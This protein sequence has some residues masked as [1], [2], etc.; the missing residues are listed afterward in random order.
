MKKRLERIKNNISSLSNSQIEL[1]E[2]IIKQ[3][4]LPY[5]EIYRHKDS[6]IFTDQVLLDF[7]DVLKI[8]HCFSYEPFTK[9]K[10]EFAL[11]R[12]LHNCNF[13]ANLAPKGNPGHDIEIN[14]IRFSLKTQA[15]KSTKS[16]KIHISKFMELGKGEWSDNPNDLNNLLNLF[17]NHLNGYDRILSLRCLQKVPFWKYEVVEIPKS[18]LFEAKY[19]ELR[20]MSKSYQNPK[21]GYCD[22]TDENGNIKF[23]LYFDGGSERKLQVK[24]LGKIYCI[25]QATWCF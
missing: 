13:N 6:D 25:V 12:T 18:L 7:G 24:N 17:F 22:V 4:N 10:F 16:D 21:P 8:H 23:Q 1:I 19:G 14:G 3:F 11:E 20:M 9:D 5:K 2:Q 15:D